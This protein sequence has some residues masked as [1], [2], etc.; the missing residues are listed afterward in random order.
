[1]NVFEKLN[2]G[3]PVDMYSE[4]YR[5]VIEELYHTDSCLFRLNHTPPRS[6]EQRRALEELFWG[7]VP[8]GPW[9]GAFSFRPLPLAV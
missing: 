6:D 7:Q 8:Q 9:P 1:M 4:E 2:N 3:D 5:P